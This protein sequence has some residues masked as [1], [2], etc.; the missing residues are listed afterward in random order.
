MNRNVIVILGIL[1]CTWSMAAGN[2]GEL[3]FGENGTFKIVQFTDTHLCAY[4]ETVLGEAEKTFARMRGMLKEE[5]PDLVVFT[6][7]VVTSRPAKVM[8]SRLMDTLNVYGVPFVVMF[9]NHDPE[10]DLT[11]AEMS[12]IITASP[13]S[14]NTLNK[15]GELADMALPI[16]DA[17]GRK[18]AAM[19]YCMDSHD[20]SKVEGIGGYDWFRRE[21]VEWLYDSC[22]AVAKKPG[23]SLPGVA[24][25]H[26]PLPEFS[27]AW[28]NQENARIGHRGEAE[29]HGKV[30][31]GMFAAMVESGGV[32]GVFCGHDHDNDYTVVEHGIALTYG[33]Y[34]G[35]KTV[36][37]HLEHGVRVTV[38]KKGRREFESWV[39]EDDGRIAYPFMFKNGKISE[40]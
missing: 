4:N 6:G 21:Q 31:A 15:D 35:D 30:N 39:R 33:R 28:S 36:Y 18:A 2:K 26:I 19:V 25:F 13:L 20:Y 3:R 32:M 34:S 23:A 16:M 17:K 38:L 9:G 7:D 10:L 12:E 5:K 27:S 29:C 14:I 40:R 24:F 22:M 1:L 8:W 37:N 11:R